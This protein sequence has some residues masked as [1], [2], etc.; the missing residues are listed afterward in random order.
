MTR[1]TDA[2]A[3]PA[4]SALGSVRAASS[5]VASHFIQG[6]PLTRNDK[7]HSLSRSTIRPLRISPCSRSMVLMA[8]SGN[9]G[10]ARRAGSRWGAGSRSRILQESLA[11]YRREVFRGQSGS[12][13][14]FDLTAFFASRMNR[15]PR[16]V[17]AVARRYQQVVAPTE[18]HVRMESKFRGA[19]Q[20]RPSFTHWH[21]I[22][23]NP[24]ATR[25]PRCSP[26][27]RIHVRS[28]NAT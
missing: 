28:P 22:V 4:V 19:A 10:I 15:C 5:M 27:S 20:E 16:T 12:R 26:A 7:S 11:F 13:E 23:V 24:P 3:S 8:E 17:L 2:R 18:Q 21:G 9:D 25:H 14:P 6:F 1:S